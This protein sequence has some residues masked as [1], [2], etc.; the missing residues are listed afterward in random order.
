MPLHAAR[1]GL[2]ALALACG[3]LGARSAPALAS[4]PTSSATGVPVC[5]ATGYQTYGGIAADGSGGFFVAWAD[6]RFVDSDVF[7]QHINGAGVAVWQAN[8]KMVG[9]ALNDQDEPALVPDGVG[10]VIVAWRDFRGGVTGD[11]YAQ[12]VNAAGN[13]LWPLNGRAICL[14]AD[15][16]ANPVLVRDGTPATLAGGAI[17]AW[18]DARTGA[19][20]YAQSASPAGVMQW[21]ANGVPVS[22]NLA[23]QFE[24]SMIADGSGGAIVA[25][26]QQGGS[27]YDIAAQHLNIV[28]APLWGAG[29]LTVCGASGTQQHPMVVRDAGTGALIVWEDRRGAN[30]D[31]YAQGYLY[32]GQRLFAADGIPVCTASG[33]QTDPMVAPDGLGGVVVTWHDTRS[34]DDI[35][36]QR[37]TGDGTLAWPPTG[38]AACTAIGVQQFPSIAGDGAGGAIVAWEDA[39]TGGTTDIWAQ[40]L[41]AAGAS[42]WGS[43]GIAASTA[44]GAQYQASVVTTGDTVGIVLWTDQR[45][46][47][48][49]IYCQRVPFVVT[50]DAPPPAAG[51]AKFSAGPNPARSD[52]TVSFSLERAAQVDVAVFDAAGRRVRSLAHG[53][54]GAGGQRVRWDARDDAGRACADGVYFARLA[55]DGRA[56]GSRVVTLRR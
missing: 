39:R 27:G 31:V 32:Y 13:I 21:A 15:E 2:F 19:R 5:T 8:G 3:A 33:D 48:S 4:W 11:I 50:L 24:P 52:V 56:A 51:D 26:S 6:L 14:A 16:Q 22:A 34:G 36:A 20:L 12:H 37:L 1:R 10:G 55:I 45:S 47:G 40:R 38:V 54:L 46:N 44:P 17:I 23:A 7:V 41:T 49:D 53:G 35:Y 28:G 9:G 25:Y 42:V 30:V 18:E 43:D 29:G